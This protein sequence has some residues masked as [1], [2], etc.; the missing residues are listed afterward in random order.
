MKGDKG[1]CVA[2]QISSEQV[3]RTKF[4]TE[5]NCQEAFDTYVRMG[6]ISPTYIVYHCKVCDGW[7]MGKKEWKEQYGK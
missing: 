1:L 7:H 6:V 5:K 3:R 4:D 2:G